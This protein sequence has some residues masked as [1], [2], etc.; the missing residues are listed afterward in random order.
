MV[1]AMARSSVVVFL[2]LHDITGDE[3]APSPKSRGIARVW[4]ESE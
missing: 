1:E 2:A 3:H 4:K